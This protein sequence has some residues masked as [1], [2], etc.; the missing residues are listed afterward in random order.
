MEGILSRQA[1]FSVSQLSRLCSLPKATVSRIIKDWE[2]GGLILSQEQG[3]N[4]L[5][6]INQNFYLLPELKSIF[7]KARDFQKPLIDRLK[8][9]PIIKSR[10]IKAIVVFGSRT[11]QDFSHA[12][13][14]DVMIGLEDKNSP[15]A[16]KIAEAFVQA[17]I[18]T[19]ITFSHVFLDKKE[20]KTRWKEKDEFIRNILAKGKILKGGKWLEHLQAAP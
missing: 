10:S 19:G 17:S 5:V 8:T 2:E 12:S 13:D 11:T 18:E 6:S 4:K 3:R 15:I 9:M 16:E 20:I 1:V 14:L 7:E